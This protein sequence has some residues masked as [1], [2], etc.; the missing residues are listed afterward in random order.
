MSALE[1]DLNKAVT[2]LLSD[3][4]RNKSLGE[5][6]SSLNNYIIT[7]KELVDNG[8]ITLDQLKEEITKHLDKK[9][10]I[11]PNSL[12]HLLVGCVGDKNACMMKSEKP[13]D[14]PFIYDSKTQTLL[15]IS[16]LTEPLT[17]DTYAVVYISGNPKNISIDAFKTLEAKGFNKLKIEYKGVANANY[18]T[19]TIDNLRHYI[20]NKPEKN[21]SFSIMI[22]G[23]LLV[24]I[25]IMYN[26][27][28]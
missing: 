5:V 24:V 23:F 19:L 25:L 17:S 20:V 2:E 4:N 1:N 12:A 28:Q 7:I 9:D 22:I 14:I 27:K 8:T 11:K 6:S 21:I 13:E 18:K 3:E 10:L 16:N 26:T 15:P